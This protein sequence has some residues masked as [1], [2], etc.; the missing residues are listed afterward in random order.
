MNQEFPS[1][2]G[3]CGAAGTEQH[4]AR[5]DHCRVLAAIRRA[6][7]QILHAAQLQRDLVGRIDVKVPALFAPATQECDG[8]GVLREHTRPLPSA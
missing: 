2:L 8:L 6:M 3:E 7:N 4:L 5:F 1:T